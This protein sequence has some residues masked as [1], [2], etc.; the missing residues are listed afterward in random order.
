MQVR[1]IRKKGKTYL[2][3]LIGNEYEGW[4]GKKILISAPTGMGKSTFV[5]GALLE[6]A[7][8]RYRKTKMLILCNRRLLR[9]QYWND[10]VQRFG[11]YAEI[12]G[13]VKVM[14]YQEL[15]EMMK[16]QIPLKDIIYEYGIIVFDECHYFYA[17]SDFNGFG[18]YALLQEIA[19]EGVKRTMIFMSATMDEVRPLIVQTVKN[20]F[21]KLSRT[22]RM[23]EDTC[24]YGEI[25]DYDFSELADYDRFQCACVPDWETLYETIAE[26]SK[27]S[28]IFLNNKEKGA[29]LADKLI[30]TGK[31]E[32]RR[33][34]Y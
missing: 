9:L 28:V 8:N 3:E 17:D 16:R 31:I 22:G 5:V 6:Y 1:V 13:S 7:K 20:C 26:S 25:L 32:K 27:K 18:T 29:A 19:C 33:L 15:A 30:R 34:L 14:T 10:L 11:S 12:V 2:T 4:D 24:D 23:T 21:T